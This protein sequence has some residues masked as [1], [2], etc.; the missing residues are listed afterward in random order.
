MKKVILLFTIATITMI[1]GCSKIELSSSLEDF[2]LQSILEKTEDLSLSYAKKSL[3]NFK[4]EYVL[5]EYSKQFSEEDKKEYE[6]EF[7]EKLDISD[8]SFS[9]FSDTDSDLEI[10]FNETDKK[11]I[12]SS[13]T[14][15]KD[16]IKTKIDKY[17]DICSLTISGDNINHIKE[18]LSKLNLSE[19][20][21]NVLDIYFEMANSIKNGAS[22]AIEDVIEKLDVDYEKRKEDLFGENYYIYDFRPEDGDS[23]IDV[24]VDNNVVVG[25]DIV[26]GISDYTNYLVRIYTTNENLLS[27]EKGFNLEMNINSNI[28]QKMFDSPQSEIKKA[29]QPVNKDLFKFAYRNGSLDFYTDEFDENKT[30]ILEGRYNTKEKA[31]VIIPNEHRVVSELLYGV[32]EHSAIIKLDKYEKLNLEINTEKEIGKPIRIN[33]I[34]ESN[35]KAIFTKEVAAEKKN[36]ILTD[37]INKDGE[38]KIIFHLNNM[39]NYTIKISAIKTSK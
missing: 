19:N 12:S 2:Y 28:N 33:L 4:Y 23:F 25:L 38:Y 32:D 6:K 15:N 36:T 13:Y 10:I 18:T 20:T 7:G 26:I 34:D 11:I 27:Q 31:Y 3:K 35:G 29:H 9:T 22:L 8:M 1:T 37:Q 17:D 5:E 30:D 16:N 24:K 21:N 14:K 39:D